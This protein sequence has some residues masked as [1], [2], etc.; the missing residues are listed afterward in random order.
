[1][2]ILY[3]NKEDNGE[4]AYIGI[5]NDFLTDSTLDFL[6]NI[7]DFKGGTTSFGNI[8]RLQKWY[9]IDGQYF[10][11]TWKDQTMQ[12]WTS[13]NYEPELLD[14]QDYIQSFINN[15]DI[16]KYNGIKKPFLN[17]CLINKYRT[18]QDSIR[19]HR[20]NQTTFGDNPTV[21]G[22][23]Y[24]DERDIVFNRIHYDPDKMNSIKPDRN[25]P[26]EI[27]VNLK[28]GSLFIMGGS[29]QKYFSHEV[30]K[31]ESDNTR[32]SMTFRQFYE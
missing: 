27:R 4:Y 29:I 8:P 13:H 17:S 3:F 19:P 24:G 7:E 22:V 6:Y 21:I 14:I 31:T 12:R 32:Y 30:P 26:E 16:Y 2:N 1:M 28:S 11:K 25:N 15:L 9:Q 20:D 10:S 5:I 18:G 23:S